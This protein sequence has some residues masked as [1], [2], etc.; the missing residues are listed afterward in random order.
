MAYNHELAERISQA[1][2]EINSNYSEKKM[3]GGIGYMVNGNM[4]CGILGG[5]LIVRVGKDAYNAALSQ[6]G[7]TEFMNNKR[8]MVGW[9][10]VHESALSSN[11]ILKEW[12]AKGVNFS[13]S[14]PG[15]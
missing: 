14:L 15:K 8:P 7:V 3:F 11:K 12:V 13:L 10:M 1:L 4:A 6:P 9:V 5:Q 2:V